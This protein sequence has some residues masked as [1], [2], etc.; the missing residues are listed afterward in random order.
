[1]SLFEKHQETIL[2]AVKANKERGFYAHY[3]ENPK[4]YG[5]E[6]P[7]AGLHAF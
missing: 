3:P 7:A 4:A 6:A 2:R 5:E 1:M